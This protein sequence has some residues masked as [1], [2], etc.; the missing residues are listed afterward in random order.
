MTFV[1]LHVVYTYEMHQIVFSLRYDDKQIIK[2]HSMS[3]NT[4][5][6]QRQFSNG[7][8]TG[9]SP[10]PYNVTIRFHFRYLQRANDYSAVLAQPCPLLRKKPRSLSFLFN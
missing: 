6:Y 2:Q 9:N 3:E 8:V 10:Q 7:D 4:V 1:Y 5:E